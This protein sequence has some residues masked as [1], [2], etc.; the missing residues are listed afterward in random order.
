MILAILENADTF[1]S[2]ENIY[3]LVKEGKDFYRVTG[4]RVVASGKGIR[5]QFQ[6][7]VVAGET[8]PAD[9][10]ERFNAGL[11]VDFFRRIGGGLRLQAGCRAR[12]AGRAGR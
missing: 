7:K 9:F 12:Y 8:L 10:T 1:E 6:L 5:N 2:G 11:Q 3:G 4:T